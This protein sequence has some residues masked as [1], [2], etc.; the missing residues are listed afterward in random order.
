VNDLQTSVRFAYQLTLSVS[1]CLSVAEWKS[2]FADDFGRHLRFVRPVDFGQP[3]FRPHKN[4]PRRTPY[5]LKE[6]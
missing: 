5:A 6:R 3:A 2:E 4:Y 1:G